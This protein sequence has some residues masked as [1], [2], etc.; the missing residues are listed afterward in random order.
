ML[1]FSFCFLVYIM[2]EI[3][4]GK[5]ANKWKWKI[6]DSKILKNIRKNGHEKMGKKQKNWNCPGATF[7]DDD[8]GPK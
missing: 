7:F 3:V 6:V 2:R 4:R 8:F 1:L 5:L